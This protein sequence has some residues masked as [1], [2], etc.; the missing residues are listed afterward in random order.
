VV[1]LVV[2][3]SGVISSG[4]STLAG[5]LAAALAGETRSFGA[6][7]RAVAAR[8]GRQETRENL[9]LTGVELIA[10]GW[11]PFVAALLD[12][13]VTTDRLVVDGIRHLE[14]V[15]ELKRQLPEADFLLVSVDPNVGL[16]AT[17]LQEDG[18]DPRALEHAVESEIP[19]VQSAADLVVSGSDIDADTS[20]VLERLGLA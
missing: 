2:G 9:Q 15:A 5:K 7:V 14:A 18:E 8:R 11:L 17:R 12:P 10:E 3:I 1:S 6:V 16:V 20:V 19:T 13:P 4:K